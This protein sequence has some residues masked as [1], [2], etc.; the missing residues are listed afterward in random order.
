MDNKLNLSRNNTNLKDNQISNS[1]NFN[2]NP[3]EIHFLKDLVK[4]SYARSI[5][6]N[7]FIIFKSKNEILYLIYTNIDNSIVSYNII[8]NKI[9]IEIKNAHYDNIINFR[10]YFDKIKNDDLIIS[11]SIDNDIKLWNINNWDNFCNLKNI[12]KSGKIFSACFLNNNNQNYILTS[13]CNLK[14]TCESIKVFDFKG[15]KIKT[16]NDSNNNTYF[17]DCYY[18]KKE[19]K[20]YIITGNIGYI[21]SYDYTN[22]KIYHLYK[23]KKDGDNHN[24]TH[25]SL[26]INDKEEIIKIIDSCQDGNIRIWIFIQEIY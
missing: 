4:D 2:S 24:I 7:T 19:S 3:K 11:I 23:D 6:D 20:N 8:D 26:I 15:N 18:D 5:L 1:I 10:Y 16:I 14:G 17:I 21:K 9:M 13:N 22:N 12:Y 25:N